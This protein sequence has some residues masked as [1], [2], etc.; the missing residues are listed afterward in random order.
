MNLIGILVLTSGAGMRE[1][2]AEAGE[3]VPSYQAG[4]GDDRG[5]RD[6]GCFEVD[7]LTLHN[8]PPSLLELLNACEMPRERLLFP[9]RWNT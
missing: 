2:V 5:D 4:G 7:K 1:E 8:A 9:L 6:D 3:G